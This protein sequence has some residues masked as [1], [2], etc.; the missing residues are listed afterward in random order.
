MAESGDTKDFT[1]MTAAELAAYD[2]PVWTH[3][4]QFQDFKVLGDGQT[5][6]VDYDSPTREIGEAKVKDGID[7]WG[8]LVSC[9]VH[10]RFG[11]AQSVKMAHREVSDADTTT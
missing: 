5:V 10:C 8:R 1:E 7:L 3:R 6:N 2:G 9:S 11:D 4:C